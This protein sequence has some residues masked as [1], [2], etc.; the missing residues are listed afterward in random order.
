MVSV[1]ASDALGV[2]AEV[3]DGRRRLEMRTPTLAAEILRVL[4]EPVP[5]A[6]LGLLGIA[7]REVKSKVPVLAWGDVTMVLGW[8]SE[9]AN[10][11]GRA[12]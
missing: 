11:Q 9:L 1:H 10:D 7:E 2:G 4:D 6:A 12:H 5:A 8:I 3:L